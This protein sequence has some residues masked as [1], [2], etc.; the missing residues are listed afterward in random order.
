MEL[1]KDLRMLAFS[2]KQI[3]KKKH[4]N[5]DHI[6]HTQ[7]GKEE[8][9]RCLQDVV[10]R[11]YHSVSCRKGADSGNFVSFKA[12][13]MLWFK[14]LLKSWK[15][16]F[17][18]GGICFMNHER[19]NFTAKKYFSTWLVSCSGLPTSSSFCPNSQKMT[20]SAMRFELSNSNF[21]CHWQ[22]TVTWDYVDS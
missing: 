18:F 1:E 12:R 20:N 4:F 3:F 7:S 14:C 19:Q 11:Y 16:T 10:I 9:F 5:Y 17:S 6:K 15:Q 2:R 8:N 22:L 21:C 13:R